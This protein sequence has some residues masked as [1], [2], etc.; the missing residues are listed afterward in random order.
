MPLILQ[1]ADKGDY[2]AIQFGPN[3]SWLTAPN[4]RGCTVEE[5]KE[6]LRNY[7]ISIRKTGATPV[8]LTSTPSSDARFAKVPSK[9][10]AS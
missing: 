5:Y 4:G 6:N 8:I 9:S 2:V 7:V 1:A 3:D 10:S